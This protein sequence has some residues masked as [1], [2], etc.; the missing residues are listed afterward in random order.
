MVTTLNKKV[1][2]PKTIRDGFVLSEKEKT[3]RMEEEE[4]QHPTPD[5]ALSTS[6][7]MLIAQGYGDLLVVYVEGDYTKELASSTPEQT[8]YGGKYTSEI[9]H[10]H[11]EWGDKNGIRDQAATLQDIFDNEGSFTINRMVILQPYDYK[12]SNGNIFETYSYHYF[13]LFSFKPRIFE[14]RFGKIPSMKIFQMLK[15]E[16]E[17][18]KKQG[19]DPETLNRIRDTLLLS[20]VNKNARPEVYRIWSGRKALVLREGRTF[21]EDGLEIL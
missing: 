11:I 15:Q 3:E 12:G 7:A 2:L 21:H 13:K 19:N 5:I 4:R 1:W 10:H 8:K 20:R 6:I 16:K 14:V 17:Q 9:F 18:W